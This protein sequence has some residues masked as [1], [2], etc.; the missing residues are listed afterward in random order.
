MKVNYNAAEDTLS[1]LFRDA[2][3]Q[4][5][6]VHHTGVVFDYDRYGMIVGLELPR[7]SEY[8]SRSSDFQ[9]VEFYATAPTPK[10]VSIDEDTNDEDTIDY[11]I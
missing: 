1:I 10:Q 4:E 6:Q 9:R 7:A 8:M 2:P 5:S 3:I 11:Y